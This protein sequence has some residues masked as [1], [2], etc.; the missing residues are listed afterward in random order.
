MSEVRLSALADLLPVGPLTVVV[1]PADEFQVRPLV[2]GMHLLQELVDC[3]HVAPQ[4]K[5]CSAETKSPHESPGN[6]A[7]AAEPGCLRALPVVLEEMPLLR[8]FEHRRPRKGPRAHAQCSRGA[9]HP[10]ACSLR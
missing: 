4:F 6:P 7:R 3:G 10:A 1:G 8:L 2:V 9:P 5:S